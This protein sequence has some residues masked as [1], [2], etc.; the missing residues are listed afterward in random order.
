VVSSVLLSSDCQSWETPTPFYQALNARWHFSLDV[1]ASPNNAKTSRFFTPEQDGLKQ[2]W[3][4]ERC[5]MNPPYAPP[6]AACKSRCS[7]KRCE[8]RGSH[9]SVYVPGQ[10][11]WVRK[12]YDEVVSNNCELVACLLPARTDTAVFHDLVMKASE[13]WFIK[14]RLQFVGAPANAVFPSMV[15][16]FDVRCRWRGTPIFNTIS[17]SLGKF[18]EQNRSAETC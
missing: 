1:C 17:G 13:V 12:A 16:L 6:Q 10:I 2:S 4:G 7:K 15:V 11:D 8:R 9:T 5:F 3:A 14:G 18:Y